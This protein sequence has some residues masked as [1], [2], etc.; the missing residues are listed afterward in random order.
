M[1]RALHDEGGADVIDAR[2]HEERIEPATRERR[3]HAVAFHELPDGA[4]VLHDGVP[5]LVLG[6]ALRSWSL[7]G[8][9]RPELRPTGI[10]T[11]I[12]PP[13]LVEV[14]RAGWH[15]PG[16]EAAEVPFLHPTA[17]GVD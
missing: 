15:A 6:D 4:V 8:Y 2:L 14:L 17:G 13:S 5:K 7:D 3:L 16:A 1:W 10:A 11:L 9:G 12:T